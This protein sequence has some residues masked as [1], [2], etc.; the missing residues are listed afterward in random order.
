LGSTF[1]FELPLE[2]GAELTSTDQRRELEGLHVLA[3]G[4][5]DAAIEQIGP[6]IEE[7]GA[8]CARADDLDSAIRLVQGEEAFACTLLYAEDLVGA[9]TA[10]ARLTRGFGANR[11][12]IVLCAAADA[13][14][15]R[16]PIVQGSYSAVLSLPADRR[17]LYNALH[18]FTATEQPE[19]VVFL[20]D[21]LKKKIG[22]R[23]LRVLVADDNAVNRD[24]LAKILERA[25]HATVLV[26][27]G[28]EA[29]DQ[30]ERETFD[31]AILDRNMPRMGGIEAVRALR[32]MELGGR[33][34]PVILLSADVT[35]EAHREAADAGA[36]LYLTKPVQASKLL[37]SLMTLCAPVAD[38][39]PVEARV[40]DTYRPSAPE[41]APV[42]N[43]ETVTLLEGL[44]SRSDFMEKLIAV[45][46]DDNLELVRKIDEALEQKRLGE[47][48]S[49]VHAM[50]GSAGSIGADRLAQACSQ[51]QELSEGDLR[52]RGKL[53]SGRLRVEFDAAR[54][55]LTDYLRK[56]RSS[57][58]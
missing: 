49:L 50:K 47:V 4:F 26:D 30:I 21:Y 42:L 3:V 20:S 52:M 54:G 45:F 23:R 6:L 35:E 22:T 39:M 10:Y 36:D 9:D 44:G 53:H 5:S 38:P 24:V 57:T 33:R 16:V 8:R 46:I 1:W 48:R 37:E 43:Y 11:M 34:L 15:H 14:V 19:G 2:I 12:P 56:R 18:S 41:V 28:E 17:L 58:G 32:I 13:N 27:N 29:L 25:N 31:A 40:V 7:W 55:E 51:L